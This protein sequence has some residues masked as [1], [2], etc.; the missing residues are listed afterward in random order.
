[1]KADF[2]KP[3]T[4]V[5][6]SDNQII[7]KNNQFAAVHVYDI[8]GRILFSVPS[9]RNVEIPIYQPGV[10][11]VRVGNEVNKVMLK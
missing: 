9:V 4:L 5:Y 1:M 3:Q 11:M 6:V 10:Y 7:V 8:S 2:V